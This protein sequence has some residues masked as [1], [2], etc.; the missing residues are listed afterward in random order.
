MTTQTVLTEDATSLRPVAR[1]LLLVDVPG[2]LRIT[3]QL[4]DARAYHVLKFLA[5]TVR[6]AGTNTGRVVR[7]LGDGFLLTFDTV[8]EA[9]AHAVTAQA[10]VTRGN[11]TEVPLKIRCGVHYGEI[12]EADG[13]AFG[14]AVYLASRVC[15]H[16]HGGEILLTDAA[17]DAS[18]VSVGSFNDFGP[19]LLPGFEDPVHLYEYPWH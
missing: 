2:S 10:E 17:Q 15:G 9:L 12:I 19:T 14:V 13:G 11:P 4:G 3:R 5:E 18:S 16:A 1:A 8:D 6:L 7:S